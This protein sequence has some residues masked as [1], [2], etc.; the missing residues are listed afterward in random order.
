MG[1]TLILGIGNLILSDDGVGI[2]AVKLLQESNEIDPAIPIV[3][4][5]T[6]GLD[7][8]Q[9]LDGTDKLIIMDASK[10][11]GTPG[12]I[13]R[14]TGDSVPAYLSIK[15]SPHEIGLPEL[16]FAAKLSKIYPKEVVI[17]CVEAESLETSTTLTPKVANALGN[18]VKLVKEEVS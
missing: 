16:L 14:I 1:R 18:V 17:Y 9:Y 5:G 4:G 2:H 8:L 11:N 3:D 7:L 13:Q 10:P 6:C 12:K 15:T